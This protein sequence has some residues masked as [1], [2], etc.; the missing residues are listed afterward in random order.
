MLRELYANSSLGFLSAEICLAWRGVTLIQY[1][2]SFD[3]L[4]AY[5]QSR[6]SKHLPTWKAFNQSAGNADASVGVWHETYQVAAG[7]SECIYANMPRYGLA[8][9]GTHEPATG[10]LRDARSRMQT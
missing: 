3:H 2:R 8:I 5:A 6:V 1:W 9:A 4:V 10:H 7:H